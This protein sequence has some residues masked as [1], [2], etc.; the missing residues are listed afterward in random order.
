[1]VVFMEFVWTLF[2]FFG[3]CKHDEREWRATLMRR[4][5]TQG[6]KRRS[7]SKAKYLVLEVFFFVIEFFSLTIG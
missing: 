2:M 4:Q 7:L 5:G 3:Y 6:L 1:M